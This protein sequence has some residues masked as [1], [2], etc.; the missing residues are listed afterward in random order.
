MKRLI[1]KNYIPPSSGILIKDID[2]KIENDNINKIMY[3]SNIDRTWQFEK[4]ID[5]P[6]WNLQQ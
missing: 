6:E 2:T 3:N 4:N 1:K 5:N